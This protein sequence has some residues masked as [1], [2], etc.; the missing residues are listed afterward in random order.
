MPIANGGTSLHSPRYHLISADLR[1][2]PEQ[3]L[4]AALSVP[5]PGGGLK[6][7]TG[8][9]LLPHLPTLLLFECVLVYMHSDASNALVRWFV[10]YFHAPNSGEPAPL[11]A[12]VYEMFGL[13]DPF[14]QVMLTNMKVRNAANHAINN[15]QAHLVLTLI[16]KKHHASW[17]CPLP[18][19]RVSPL[20]IFAAWVSTC[21][22]AHTTR[23]T[24]EVYQARGGSQV[25]LNRS[26]TC[27]GK[28][29]MFSRT[30]KLEMLDE[31]EELELVLAHYAIT[32]GVKVGRISGD[33]RWAAWK[34][35][36]A[37]EDRIE[38]D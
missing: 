17:R 20:P 11:G 36:P 37:P 8:P 26:R 15:T 5:V 22:G 21:P 1:Q 19:F 16:G 33:S 18:Q 2:A 32:W 23:Y 14:G 10:D 38:E 35:Q 9:I 13:Q 28:T 24:T 25:S 3:S 4:H 6:D 30:S 31:L 7:D 12:I 27:T 29:D 34:L